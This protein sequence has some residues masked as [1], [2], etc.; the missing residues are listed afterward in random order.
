MSFTYLS[1]S[2][3]TTTNIGTANGFILPSEVEASLGNPTIEGSLLSSNTDGTRY[4]ISRDSLS[5]NSAVFATNSDIANN[6][7]YLQGYTWASPPVIGE[8]SPNSAIFTEVS[9]TGDIIVSQTTFI[10]DGSVNSTFYTG[11]SNNS[12]LLEGVAPSDLNVNSAVYATNSQFAFT[13]NNSVLLNGY[14]SLYFTNASNISTG[15]LGVDR[16]ANSGVIAGT[17]G[18][19][20]SIPVITVDDKGRITFADSTFVN[21]ITGFTYS[22]ANS[23]FIITTGSG[24]VYYAP[25]TDLN[26]S[27]EVNA[28]NSSFNYIDL[29]TGEGIPD[30]LEGRLYW[31]NTLHQLAYKTDK[32]AVT[33]NPGFETLLRVYNNSGVAIQ[34][35]DAVYVTGADVNN[36]PTVEL[37]DASNENKVQV[38]GLSTMLIPNGEYGIITRFGRVTPADTSQFSVGQKI[39]LSPTTPGKYTAI[40]PTY[41]NFAVRLGNVLVANTVGSVLVNLQSDVLTT[42]RVLDSV[43]I[44]GNLTVD[45]DITVTGNVNTTSVTNLSVQDNFI[46]LNSGDTISVTNFSGSG[47]ND[48]EFH[49]TFEGP[50]AETFYVKIDSTGATDTF[51]WSN[52]NFVTTISN[53]IPITSSFQ[54]LARGITIRFQA[55]T[56][57]T[58]ND[59]WSGTAAP[60]NI[61]FGIVG[62]YNDGVYQHGGL[63]RDATDGRF[64]VFDGYLPEPSASTNIDVD[65]PSFNLGIFQAD[66]FIGT[67]QGN[68]DSATNALNAN[69]SAY[70]FGKTEDALNVNSAVYST[71]SQFAY[72][73]NLANY[74]T[75]AGTLGGF[76][77]ANLNVNSAVY[78]TN[79]E[80]AFVANNS[81][82]LQ[83]KTWEEPGT[84]GSVT[85]NSGNFTTVTAS[86]YT[87]NSFN[88]S[89]SGQLS[90]NAL[91]TSSTLQTILS[92]YPANLFASS[93]MIIQA[94]SSGNRHITE[95]ILTSNATHVVAT[96]YGTVYTGS[97]PI[98]SYDVDLIEGQVLI[99]VT[100][101]SA[102][103]TTFR[104]LQELFVA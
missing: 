81:N 45:G 34:D 91:T 37:A 28:N 54:P 90:G 25:I 64:K 8:F 70:A 7:Y 26:I 14:N 12:K 76:A 79:S 57:H 69:N 68:A 71:N 2:I 27:G 21:G 95:M 13:S 15:T 51:A 60:V 29:N 85:P 38:I 41:P 4:W 52:D 67:L 104:V 103:T 16:L 33:V 73:A 10:G 35:G 46:Y 30:A 62:N 19:N 66:T 84:I 36:I 102:V 9:V 89:T 65:D 53:N 77:A 87:G 1:G 100:P 48:A 24:E 61:D 47:L 3:P 20:N 49:G 101:E 18:N 99:F 17:Y 63:F 6:S 56:G 92:A 88:I 82:Y 42:L 80:F 93:K 86:S 97:G 43:R 5:V 31:D 39:Y 23:T 44:G 75:D 11:T 40:A 59:I 94:T 72:T 78:S 98:A 55:N 50:T 22:S 58:L 74:S 96:E 32:S 83:N